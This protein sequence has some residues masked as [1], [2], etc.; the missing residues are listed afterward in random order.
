[1]TGRGT[2]W[3]DR[4]TAVLSDERKAKIAALLYYIVDSHI[5]HCQHRRQ[6]PEKSLMEEA[7]MYLNHVAAEQAT[8]GDGTRDGEPGVDEQMQALDAFKRAVVK[9]GL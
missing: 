6:C 1:M 3:T 2:G 7:T 4:V 5:D 8:W 9:A